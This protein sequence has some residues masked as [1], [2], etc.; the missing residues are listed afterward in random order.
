M[1][2]V[3]QVRCL[4]SKPVHGSHQSLRIDV[5]R[6]TS[7]DCSNHSPFLTL[8]SVSLS[9]MLIHSLILTSHLFFCL[10]LLF[11][12]WKMG[13]HFLTMLRG[14]HIAQFQFWFV[15]CDVVSE[16]VWDYWDAHKSLKASHLHSFDFSQGQQLGSRIC[17]HTGTQYKGTNITR[18]H[19][20][21]IFNLMV[22][23]LLFQVVL[24]LVIMMWL[25]YSGE[26]FWPGTSV[27]HYGSK[28]FEA[29][30]LL[31][32]W[33]EI[34]IFQIFLWPHHSVGSTSVPCPIRNG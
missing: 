29:A 12:P 27:C 21:R 16:P 6:A 22:M 9:S 25:G 26:Y 17:M 32:N 8:F 31:S 14:C 4:G 13:L 20:S 30:D 1:L 34:S 24:S 18:R 28:I 23:F 2:L 11:P 10:S 5:H 7:D 33:I 19:T 15:I 3:H